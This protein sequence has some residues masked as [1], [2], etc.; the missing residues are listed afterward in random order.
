MVVPGFNDKEHDAAAM[1]KLAEIFGPAFRIVMVQARAII[2]GMLFGIVIPL[3][4]FFCFTMSFLFSL[5]QRL[6]AGEIFIALHS[7]SQCV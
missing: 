1:L 6:Q 3:G 7:N 4:F 5:G 2:L